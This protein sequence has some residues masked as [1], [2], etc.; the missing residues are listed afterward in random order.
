MSTR[1]VSTRSWRD[2]PGFA[3]SQPKQPRI[4][5]YSNP[6]VVSII[7]TGQKNLDGC[8]IGGDAGLAMAWR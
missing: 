4:L 6:V 3:P 2:A 1:V 5:G 8:V 7:P